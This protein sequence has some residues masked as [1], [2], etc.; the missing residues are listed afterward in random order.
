MITKFIKHLKHFIIMPSVAVMLVLLL[1]T[2]EEGFTPELD[3]KYENV[4]VVE[5]EISNAPGPYTV[6]LTSSASFNT[7]K[8]IPL[9]GYKVVIIDDQ[10]NSEIL[11]EMEKG[12]YTSSPDGIRG[13]V[14]REYKLSIVAT[15][16]QEYE[17]EFE[18]LRP[19]PPIDSVYAKI[20]TVVNDDLPY[21]IEG[22]RFYLNTHTISPEPTYLLW[23][24]DATYKYSADLIIRWMY[25]GQLH[26]YTNSDSLRYCWINNKIYTYFLFN[27]ENVNT[28]TI[29]DFPLHYV[30]T[31]VRDLS[32]RYSLLTKQYSISKDAYIFWSNVKEQNEN[33]GDLY[34]KQPFQIRG[35]VFNINNKSEPVLGYFMVAG[36]SEKRIFVNKPDPPV[37]MRYGECKL[38][39]Q[40]YW[41]FGTLF[42]SSP[43]EWPEFAT[44]DENGVSAYPP[45]VCLDCREKGGSIE[46]PGF[47]IDN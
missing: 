9:T 7:S 34:T 45:Q 28:N 15:N 18:I 22:Y 12:V 44:F 31:D 39:E 30:A 35:N 1:S 6:K 21:N 40:D 41:N 17:S 13:I 10:E 20:E 2:C 38:V 27:N 14:G 19:P 29:R 23:R 3:S 24:L 16:G 37:V 11:S 32:I 25:D 33:L 26:Q 36:T 4:M 42:L 43:A 46:K 8:A 5:G 47:W